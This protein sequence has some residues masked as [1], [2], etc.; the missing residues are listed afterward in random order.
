MSS[1]FDRRSFLTHSAATI[2]GVAMAGT[3]VDGLLAGAAG[4][5]T[6]VSTK[7]PK[8]GGTL[9]VGLASDVPNY[10]VFNGAQGK[11]DQSGF[12]VAN[13]LYDALFVASANGK[14]WL[15]MLALSAT[16][17]KNYTV[18]TIALRQGVTYTNGDVFNA[19]TVVA[20]FQAAA[21]D[22]TVGLAIQPIIKSC[23]ASDTYT[24]VYTLQIP[25]SSFPFGA[26]AEQQTSYMAHPSSFSSTF[27]GNP[28]GT[29]PFR[30]VSW[31][32]GVESKFKKNKHYWRSDAHN[33]QLPYLN[34]INFK[35][36][37]DP[38]ARNQALQTGAIDMMLQQ[39]ATSVKALARMKG[40]TYRT[41][42]KDP[43]DPSCNCLI[44]NTT[45]TLN[46]YFAWAGEFTAS[47]GIPGGLSY[48]EKGQAIPSAVQMADYEGTLGAVDP[49]S[50]QWNTKLKPVIS[51]PTIRRALAMTINRTTYFKVLD[52]GVGAV[53]DGVYRH[54]S[55]NY[56]N[57]HYPAYNPTAAKALV[58][59]YKTKN[60][61]S[62]VGFVIDIISGDSTANRAFSFFAQQCAAVGIKVTPRPLV[63]SALINNVIYGEFDCSQWNQF[64]G[65][66]PALNYVWFNSFPATTSPATGG[67]GMTALPANTFIAGAVNFSHLGDPVIEQ[68]MLSAMALPHG[69]TAQH[70]AWAKVNAQFAKDVPYLF[71]DFLVTAWA[72]RNNVQNWTY[73]TAGD[74]RTR[75]LNP[76]GGS[77][78]W[79]QI[80]K[81]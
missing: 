52:A 63:Q 36:I 68:S 46:Q 8:L 57:P 59:A 38:S 75:C 62:S 70:A 40:I 35:T 67:L 43:T 71:L 7:K 24:V 18:W 6:G 3:V 74:G 11:M 5:A 12:C 1:E 45:G 44:L 9:T 16:P 28:V 14:T 79:D 47:L 26:L 21:A 19:A 54:T 13:A 20:N 33:R 30:I 4:A 15:P 65:V 10:H 69:S 58:K 76:D 50:L 81:S 72:A 37:V 39:D 64:G 55:P 17:N 31:Q 78:R 60:S 34:A 32:V 77:T 23:V 41:D 27:T 49:S 80:W 48:I 61:V 56:K 25:Y 2:G 42:A 53:S 51:D 22:P 29:G 73:A 66:D